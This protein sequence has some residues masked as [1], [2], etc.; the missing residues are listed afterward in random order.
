MPAPNRS[1]LRGVVAVL[2]GGVVIVVLLVFGIMFLAGWGSVPV[3]KVGLH[4]SGGPI[5]GQKFVKVIEPGTGAQFLG[6]RD[7]LVHLP[8][9]QRDYVASDDLNAD[10]P[11][12]VAPA[13]GGVEMRFE[14]A[15]YFALNT[16]DQIVRRFYERVCVKFGCT[17]DQGWDRMLDVTFRRPIEQAI[18]QAIRGYTVN[19]LYAGVS[20]EGS[21]ETDAEN[22]LVRVQEEI[23]VDLKDNINTVLGGAYFCGPSF[24]RT[25][26][27][28]CPDFE[29]QIVEVVPTKEA[30][31]NAFSDNAASQQEIISAENRAAAAVAEAQGQADA[32]ARIADLFTDPNYIA[33]LQAQAMQECARNSNCTLVVTPGGTNVNV[34]TGAAPG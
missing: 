13:K 8:I 15:A 4:Y 23:A 9:T 2:G 33:Y 32:A 27:D 11:P 3:D 12:I 22:V 34:N 25:T 20:A 6:L 14:V 1:N 17:S 7:K 31:I 18:Q 5:E 30:V 16:G 21:G 24:D 29:F 19:E 10:G 28:E 26:P